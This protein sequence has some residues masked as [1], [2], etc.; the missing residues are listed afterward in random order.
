MRKSNEKRTL[1]SWFG[2][3][4]AGTVLSFALYRRTGSGP[5]LSLGITCLTVF[6]H[7][8]V[9]LLAAWLLTRWLLPAEPDP[10]GPWFRVGPREQARY[11]RWQVKRWKRRLPTYAPEDFSPRTH[12]WDEIVRATCR[13]EVVHAVN[14]PLSFVPLAFSHWFGCAKKHSNKNYSSRRN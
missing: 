5:A 4:L 9:R 12:T 13:A 7:L 8:A 1:W 2:G 11:A 14:I 10:N 3:S 6:Y